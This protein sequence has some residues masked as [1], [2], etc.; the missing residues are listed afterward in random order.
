MQLLLQLALLLLQPPLILQELTLFHLQV[1]NLL[2]VGLELLLQL[3]QSGQQCIT[4]WV[5][6]SVGFGYNERCI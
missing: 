4:L 6:R 2:L 5:G 1:P 3:C